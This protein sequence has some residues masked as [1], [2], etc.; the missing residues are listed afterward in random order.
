M[1]IGILLTGHGEFSIG[2][3]HALKMIAGEQA[4]LQVVP[5]NDGESLDV[6]SERLEQAIQTLISEYQQAIIFT[7]LLGGTPFNT[8]KMLT[9][10]NNQVVVLTGTNLPMLIEGAMLAQVLDDVTALAEQLV[11][12]G[13][14]GIQIPTLPAASSNDEEEDGI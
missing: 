9:H 3:S 10:Q 12:V 11:S 1:T 8:S 2:L 13:Q 4:H 14:Q 6:Y 5:F 7:D